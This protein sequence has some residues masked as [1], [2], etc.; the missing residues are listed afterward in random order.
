MDEITRSLTTK[1]EIIKHI[2]KID[3]RGKA[4]P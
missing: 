2:E 1:A 3:P 4:M